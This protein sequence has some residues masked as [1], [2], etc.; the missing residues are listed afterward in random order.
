MGVEIGV[1]E[2]AE[3]VSRVILTVYCFILPINAIIAILWLDAILK[4]FNFSFSSNWAFLGVEIGVF[5]AAEQFAWAIPNLSCFIWL[6]NAIIAIYG[7]TQYLV[8]LFFG[9]YAINIKRHKVEVFFF[10]DE[11]LPT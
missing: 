7:R 8:F 9:S 11:Q 5:E 6:I 2:A 4:F 3:Q 1:I 10:T